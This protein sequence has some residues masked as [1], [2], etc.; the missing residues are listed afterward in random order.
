MQDLEGGIHVA[1]LAVDRFRLRGRRQNSG[2]SR[3]LEVLPAKFV[4]GQGRRPASPRSI[5]PDRSPRLRPARTPVHLHNAG[6]PPRDYQLPLLPRT[7]SQR[8]EYIWQ[9]QRPISLP[10]A[11]GHTLQR[12]PPFAA[13]VMP[14]FRQHGVTLEEYGR[15]HD[16][17]VGFRI[18]S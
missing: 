15:S 17:Y 1:L 9:L 3:T 13:Q 2:L 10:C 18:A 4:A 14:A 16:I 12:R 11:R 6:P 5:P 8:L 7:S